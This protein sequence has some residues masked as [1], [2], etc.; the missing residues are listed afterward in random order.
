[1]AGLQIADLTNTYNS[2]NNREF[3]GK[4]EY[5]RDRFL[6]KVKNEEPFELTNGDEMFINIPESESFLEKIQNLRPGERSGR[7]GKAL[8]V[9]V[10]E[11][12]KLSKQELNEKDE[13]F[14]EI[15]LSFFQKTE[16]FGSSKETTV[17]S[18]E[19]VESMVAAVLAF[20][21]AGIV[22]TDVIP[23][24]RDLEQ[25]IAQRRLVLG[26]KVT[27][28]A[29]HASFDSLSMDING[30][31]FSTILDTATRLQISCNL[32]G[33]YSI[34]RTRTEG[35][36]G[37]IYSLFN[38]YNE[39]YG[40]PDKW[41]PA[42]IWAVKTG[43][44]FTEAGIVDWTTFN[45]KV[46]TAFDE[47]N[48]IGISL[49]QLGSNPSVELVN[50]TGKKKDTSYHVSPKEL[51]QATFQVTGKSSCK[52]VIPSRGDLSI[53]CASISKASSFNIEVGWSQAAQDG[54][55]GLPAI[56]YEFKKQ[57]GSRLLP[58]KLGLQSDVVKQ[59]QEEGSE[60]R[61][62][63]INLLQEAGL[64]PAKYLDNSPGG[65]LSKYLGLICYHNYIQES[66]DKVQF[67][68]GILDYAMS[69]TDEAAPHYKIH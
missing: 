30:K 35:V 8:V 27:V 61:Q 6:E 25:L 56:N 41:N 66:F 37:K 42:D 28:D 3:V 5:R 39:R 67:L 43:Y 31:W 48:A 36:P 54:K 46:R 53:R 22:G 2:R 51:E 19:D 62:D 7:L 47:G 11:D 24:V 60:I 10:R 45:Q 50:E 69:R 58:A 59:L 33:S 64:D 63:F 9:P 17:G 18:T 16:E 29:L 49:K 57:Q 23:T 32:D 20:N 40:Q 52:I 13:F 65:L 55:A 34:Y 14:R 26:S 1:M 44:E 38:K 12:V 68:N 4:Y 21:L 15:S